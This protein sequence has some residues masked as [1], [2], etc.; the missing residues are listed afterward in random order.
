AQDWTDDKT[1]LKKASADF[2]GKGSTAITGALYS[3]ADHI[4]KQ[5]QSNPGEVRRYAV[6][7]ISDGLNTDNSFSEGKLV[8]Q[9][10]NLDI[11]VFTI[12]F[13]CGFSRPGAPQVPATQNNPVLVESTPDA[14]LDNL[15]R[16]TGGLSFF[17]K[18]IEELQA[19][20]DNLLEWIRNQYV[21][22]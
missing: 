9:L 8:S 22:G 11:Q 5:M 13:P 19:I 15:M 3:A 20:C 4:E 1:L 17:P 12:C 10:R 21:I 7:L 18:N 14:L 16:V 6:I 2:D